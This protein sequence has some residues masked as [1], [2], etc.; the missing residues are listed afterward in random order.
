VIVL[1]AEG[2]EDKNWEKAQ[3][4]Y[5]H[6][7][8]ALLSKK[9]L[10]LYEDCE[11]LVPEGVRPTPVDKMIEVQPYIAEQ[12]ELSNVTASGRKKKD[13]PVKR[14]R[15]GV[16]DIPAGGIFGFVSAKDYAVPKSKAQ[17]L[18]DRSEAA[19]LTADE[20]AVLHKQWSKNITCMPSPMDAEN[21]KIT[22]L[23]TSSALGSRLEAI[24][25]TKRFARNVTRSC[26]Y[27]KIM[28]QCESY[29]DD[30][31]KYEA[32][33]EDKMARLDSKNVKWWP[34][35]L[36]GKG[37]Q[38]PLKLCTDGPN[39]IRRRW[40]RSSVAH[41]SPGTLSPRVCSIS[42][43]APSSPRR[44][45]FA[46]VSDGSS[47]KQRTKAWSPP[48]SHS[49]LPDVTDL[50][51]SMKTSERLLP[52]PVAPQ[53]LGST[54][55]TATTVCG[56][57]D[58]KRGNQTS[59]LQ[60]LAAFKSKVGEPA[61]YEPAVVVRAAGASRDQPP[62]VTPSGPSGGRAT[63]GKRPLMGPAR[64]FEEDHQSPLL[65]RAMT[66]NKQQQRQATISPR[67]YENGDEFVEPSCMLPPATQMPR[68]KR[69]QRPLESGGEH[70]AKVKRT[71]A[72]ESSDEMEV[73]PGAGCASG[74]N[75]DDDDDDDDEKVP[76]DAPARQK[77]LPS[78]RHTHRS[79]KEG[80]STLARKSSSKGKQK[81]VAA[82]APRGD[83][84]ALKTGL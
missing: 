82:R 41:E 27:S 77:Q 33:R 65:L 29:V 52:P 59:G 68:G 64:L 28:D 32:W 31:A 15:P 73:H 70:Q 37:A 45:S 13:K 71:I 76:Q 1:I 54:S 57:E 49:D 4:Q 14:K 53:P 10:E 7:Q 55:S 20:A 60:R 25:S 80:S 34:L 18:R 74:D 66:Q 23:P 51:P 17:A 50:I 79:K 35:E 9:V 26:T 43:S 81:Q 19:L 2:R 39:S 62:P 75:D 5:Q 24:P 83:R 36:R 12:V 11:R 22:Y 30:E 3:D 47:K 40:G 84:W 16:E 78:R 63:G 61:P 6:V 69:A 58:G 42:S 21:L 46:K 56:V 44:V 67:E 38:K 72:P 8:N 48:S